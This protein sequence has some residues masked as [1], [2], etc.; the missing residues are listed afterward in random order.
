MVAFFL[1][2]G[3]VA[4]ADCDMEA[5][6]SRLYALCGIPRM[7]SPRARQGS[8]LSALGFPAPSDGRRWISTLQV[9]ENKMKMQM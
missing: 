5:I 7:R 6:S 3:E 1:K 4:E 9:G 8:T 2:L